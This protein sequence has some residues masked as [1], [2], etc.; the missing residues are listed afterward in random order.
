MQMK[1][2]N[3]KNFHE[4]FSRQAEVF[5]DNACLTDG[6]R[7]GVFYSFKDLNSIA[8]RVAVFL[9]TLGIKKGDRFAVVTRNSPEFMFLY[10][11]S[12]KLGSLIMPL[13]V[14]FPPEGILRQVRRFGIKAIFFSDE[15]RLSVEEAHRLDPGVMPQGLD[16]S[17]LKD[18]IKD[19]SQ[20]TSLFDGV[21]LDDPGSFYFSS[22]TTGEPKGIPQSPRNLL[23]AA[24]ALIGVYGFSP[25]D[26][27]MGV[28]PCYH[29]AL[30]TYGFW[31]SFWVGSNFVLFERF[32][33]TD[34][35]KNLARHRASF[36]EVVPTILSM[37]LYPPEDI[38]GYDLTGL[39]FIGS[40]SAP[41]S[42]ALH[43][44]FEDTFGIKVANQYGLSEAAPTH[45][46]PPERNLRKEGSIGKP[47]ANVEA[48]VVNE[49]GEELPDMEQG[50][51]IM[52]GDS[53]V[54]GYYNDPEAT[55]EAFRDGWFYT[56]DLGY[57]DSDRFYFLSGRKK[58][59]IIRGGEK[60]YPNEVDNVLATCAGIKE[61]ATVGV[62][63]PF[64]GEEVVSY[65]VLTEDN[66]ASEKSIKKHCARFLP[67]YKCP[68]KIFFIDEVPKTASGKI[69]RRKLLELYNQNQSQKT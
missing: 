47:M 61:S 54:A 51:I 45:F 22:G 35:W 26:T 56:G 6:D 15:S 60:I 19:I 50:E 67:L 33:K 63:D 29:T 40:G 53:V 44:K 66:V 21:S 18:S 38:S 9:S 55:N 46:N 23:A 7:P 42:P 24:E 11:A 41:L 17:G 52:K 31:P 36:V 10:L 12:M 16:L 3:F 58:E 14:D 62:P 59:M 49:K 48:K 57:R 13:V 37:L 25:K 4:F 8:T 32:H 64:Y 20:E 1:L 43:H 2:S 28:L 5:G 27:Q 68:K 69:I 30:A 39:K 34:F 65:V